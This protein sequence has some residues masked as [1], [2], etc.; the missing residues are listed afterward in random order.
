MGFGQ[1]VK[2]Y[3]EIIMN[4]KKTLFLEFDFDDRYGRQYVHDKTELNRKLAA[5]LD[6]LAQQPHGLHQHQ[7]ICGVDG[8]AIFENI[9]ESF[10]SK[11]LIEFDFDDRYG[12]K[13]IKQNWLQ[14]WI[15]IHD[16]MD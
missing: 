13:Y 8:A 12:K 6:D 16:L 15:D 7:I 4:N 9:I 14:N 2:Q 10:E 3:I 11:L 5:L 1:Q